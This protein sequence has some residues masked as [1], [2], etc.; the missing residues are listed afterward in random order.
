MNATISVTT[1]TTT[2]KKT[3]RSFRIWVEGKKLAAAGFAPD[4]RYS[5]VYGDGEIRLTLSD[6]GERRVTKASRNGKDRAIIDLHCAEVGRTFAAGTEVTVE[7]HPS[8]IIFRSKLASRLR[9]ALM[10]G[11]SEAE[12]D[13][14]KNK[15]VFLTV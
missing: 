10:N 8:I 3:N 14:I 12:K 6:D 2:V 13:F 4:A 5:V 7:Y 11:K 15:V 1:S 9:D